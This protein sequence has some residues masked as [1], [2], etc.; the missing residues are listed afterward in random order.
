MCV[1]VIEDNESI[2]ELVAL[3]LE[4]AGYVVARARDGQEALEVLAHVRPSIILLDLQMPRMDGRTFASV[5]RKRL[6]P[7][8]PIVLMTASSNPAQ[9]ARE[10]QAMAY[11]AKPFEADELLSLVE[12]AAA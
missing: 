1:L 11:L 8:A 12:R 10:T 3:T 4:E 2:R 9:A 7:G 5:Y 6:H